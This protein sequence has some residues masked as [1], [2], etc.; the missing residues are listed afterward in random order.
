MKYTDEE[1]VENLLQRSLSVQENALLDGYIESVSK[2]I[3]SYTN[4]KWADISTTGEVADETRYFDTDNGHSVFVDDFSDPTSI[5]LID[6]YGNERELVESDYYQL[7]P[8]NS[9]IK[10]EIRLCNSL[11]FRK[12]RPGISITAK[13]SLELPEA[14][15][16]VATQMVSA[17][18]QS[19][20]SL[21]QSRG[22]VSENIEGYSYKVNSQSENTAY[23][24]NLL[25]S[26]D[27]FRK[28]CL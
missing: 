20:S 12:G 10:N 4:R 11:F 8:L 15:K 5:L 13:F 2:L 18:I 9:D 21:V 26:L 28:P 23:Q 3:S 24:E 1:N 25:S 22:L 17:R 7:Y 16:I 6:C 19:V 27:S 14:V